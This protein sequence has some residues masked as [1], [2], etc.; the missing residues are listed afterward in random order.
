M[1]DAMNETPKNQTQTAMIFAL[2]FVKYTLC[3]IGC[4]MPKYRSNEI[5]IRLYVEATINPHI[6]VRLIH[7]LQYSVDVKALPPRLSMGGVKRVV[8]MSRRETFP[9]MTL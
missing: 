4:T 5:A 2:L 7:S 8:K 3:H 6:R 9:S 1:I